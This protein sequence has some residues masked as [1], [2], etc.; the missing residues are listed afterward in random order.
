M[1]KR[2]GPVFK[3]AVFIVPRIGGG[4]YPLLVGT[5]QRE[6]DNEGNR[7]PNCRATVLV[8]PMKQVKKGE[9]GFGLSRRKDKKDPAL[10]EYRRLSAEG[11]AAHPSEDFL[12]PV[13]GPGRRQHRKSLRLEPEYTYGGL[14]MDAYLWQDASP[15][16]CSPGYANMNF[17]TRATPG[18]PSPPIG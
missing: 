18:P 15:V 12:L 9:G 5:H 10:L 2:I 17:P 1:R 8:F 13:L 16:P 11:A 3:I 4:C 7:P 14:A 6:I